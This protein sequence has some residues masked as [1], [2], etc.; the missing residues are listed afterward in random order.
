MEL[1]RITRTDDALRLEGEID[2]GVVDE[3]SDALRDSIA[4]GI[5]TVDLSGVSFMD[6]SGLH[7][8]VS[9]KP[10]NGQGPLVLLHPSRSVA[11]LLDIALPGSVPGVVIHAD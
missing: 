3:L 5:T 4:S 11:R 6:S 10:L 2:I 7:V 8:L 9:A 1:L